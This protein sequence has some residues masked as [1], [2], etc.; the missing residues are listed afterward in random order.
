MSFAHLLTETIYVGKF[1]GVDEYGDQSYSVAV[2]TPA[3]V[4]EGF[5]TVR[6]G[7]GNERTSAYQVAT[8]S[9]IG[10]QDRV[11]LPGRDPASDNEAIRPMAITSDQSR[12][13]GLR[14]YQTF[15]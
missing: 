14:L 3:A 2:E 7:G 4:L 8:S 6:D 15:F 1:Q 12:S 10:L 13:S 11:W 9:R 5:K